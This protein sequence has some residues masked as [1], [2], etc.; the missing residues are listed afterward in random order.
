[1]TCGADQFRVF[2]FEGK[3]GVLVMVKACAFP[4]FLSVAGITLL[5]VT[6]V[7]L[8]IIFM[9][10]VAVLFRLYLVYRLPVTGLTGDIFMFPP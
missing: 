10:A 5:A 9:T 4:A 3:L 8:V 7:V 6:P 2:A 1:M